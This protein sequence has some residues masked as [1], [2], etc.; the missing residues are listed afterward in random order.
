MINDRLYLFGDQEGF[1]AIEGH[2]RLCFME[3]LEKSMDSRGIAVGVAVIGR[4]KPFPVAIT[5]GDAGIHATGAPGVT[6]A[7][8]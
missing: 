2:G 3:F 4:R 8:D 6:A 1:P 7:G 5:K